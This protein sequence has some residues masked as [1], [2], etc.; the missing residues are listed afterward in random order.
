MKRSS[1]FSGAFNPAEISFRPPSFIN[2]GNILR[3]GGGSASPQ[4]SIQALAARNCCF[5]GEYSGE[6]AIIYRPCKAEAQERYKANDQSLGHNGQPFGS[7][8]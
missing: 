7:F 3:P 8:V 2:S 6:N 5:H 1:G 4:A